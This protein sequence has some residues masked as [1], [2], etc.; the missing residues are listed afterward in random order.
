M[1]MEQYSE[2]NRKLYPLRFIEAGRDLFWGHLDYCI[3]DD[4]VVDTV[5]RDGWLGG[6]TLGELLRTFHERIAGDNVFDSFG[7]QFPVMVNRQRFFERQ[8]L[9]I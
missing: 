2:E 8:P 6:N 7:F 4:A 3:S 1:Q 5:V 9:T